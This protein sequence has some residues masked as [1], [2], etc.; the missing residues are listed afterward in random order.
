M[1]FL[2]R[3]AECNTYQLG[4]YLPFRVGE[5]QLGWV[6]R[7]FAPLLA[8]YGDVFL[9]DAR[10][11]ALHPRLSSFSERSDALAPVLRALA[12]RGAIT[13]WRHENYPVTE[14]FR[15]RPELQIERAAVTY[16]G[17][18]SYGVHMNGYVRKADGLYL[19]VPRRSPNKPT[20]PGLLDN[21]V[22]GGQPIG[23][24]LAENLIKECAEEANIPAALARRARPVSVITYCNEVAEGL[25][26]DAQFCFDLE[27]PED[28]VPVNTDGEIAAFYLWPIE[29]VAQLVRDTREFKFN[30]NLVI[31]DFLMRHG[32]LSQEDPDYIEIA[33]GLRASTAIC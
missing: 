8:E 15:G 10:A 9:V 3:I 25:Q 20:Y 11:V 24:G 6:R 19:W 27:L 26:P 1:S 30:C 28:F 5:R 29:R 2:D 14:S 7:E 22:A 33:Q 21:T 16:F 17:L 18:R 32:L 13:G 23:A 4:P 31:I 12:E